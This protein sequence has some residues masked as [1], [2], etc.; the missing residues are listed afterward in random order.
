MQETV[1]DYQLVDAE[2]E[3]EDFSLYTY[4]LRKPLR[5]RSASMLRSLPG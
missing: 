3:E 4:A 5:R 2:D 1:N